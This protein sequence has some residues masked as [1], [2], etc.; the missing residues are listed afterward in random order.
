M[1]DDCRTAHSSERMLEARQ[2]RVPALMIKSVC[3]NKTLERSIRS[4]PRPVGVLQM[5]ARNVATDKRDVSAMFGVQ[6]IWS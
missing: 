5:I 2:R 1:M 3:Q 6:M 4:L